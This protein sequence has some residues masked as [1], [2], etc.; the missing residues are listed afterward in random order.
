MSLSGG[1]RGGKSRIVCRGGKSI[2]DCGSTFSQFSFLRTDCNASSIS[3]GWINPSQSQLLSMVSKT[4][5]APP[6]TIRWKVDMWVA[7]IYTV[8]YIKHATAIT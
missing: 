5:Q 8:L 7:R 2:G 3:V 4:Y 6:L 1:Y